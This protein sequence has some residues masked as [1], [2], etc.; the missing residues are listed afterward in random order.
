MVAKKLVVVTAVLSRI[1]VKY[2]QTL[3]TLLDVGVGVKWYP[4]LSWA[5]FSLQPWVFSM[6][7]YKE[8]SSMMDLV[9][10]ASSGAISSR[11]ICA[12]MCGGVSVEGGG[13][14]LPSTLVFY[15][16]KVSLCD[17]NL[18]DVS[19]TSVMSDISHVDR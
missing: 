19:L 5:L 12:L 15:L 2:R 18:C 16:S 1:G 8:D 13:S 7:D 14:K 17:E 10:R 11:E 6:A 4:L 3:G 9:L